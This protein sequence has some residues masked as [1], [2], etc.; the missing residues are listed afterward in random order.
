MGN[1][2]SVELCEQGEG[3]VLTGRGRLCINREGMMCEQGEG[4]V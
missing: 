4:A 1:H 3:A 2:S